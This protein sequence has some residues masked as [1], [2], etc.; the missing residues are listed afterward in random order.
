MKYEPCPFCEKLDLTNSKLGYRNYAVMCN[1]CGAT[2]PEADTKDQADA[3][4][5]VRAGL[6]LTERLT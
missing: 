4:W 6:T 2:G 1:D 5:N 3:A